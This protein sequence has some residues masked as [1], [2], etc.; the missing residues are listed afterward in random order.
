M[1]LIVED[2]TGVVDANSYNTLQELRDYATLRGV[3]LPTDAALTAFAVIATD[4]LES[5]GDRFVGTL[6]N[7]DQALSWPR[8]NV[9]KSDGSPFPTNSIPKAL[10]FAQCQLC[11]EQNNGIVIMPS[12]DNTGGFVI[13]EKIDTIETMYSQK[14][15]PS[16]QPYLPLVDSLLQSLLQ[17][18]GSLLRCVRV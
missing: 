15:V 9:L 7:V 10:K 4:Y 8:S 11:V 17:N 13:R 3:T 18:G 12:V 5:F 14:V 2:G 1:P 16:T 6:T